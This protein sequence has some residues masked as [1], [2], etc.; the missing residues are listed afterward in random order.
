MRR[1]LGHALM[2]YM[3]HYHQ[4]HPHQ[5]PGHIVLMPASSL[6]QDASMRCRE[7]FGGLLQY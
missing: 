1:T 7:P 2:E 6:K 4:E 3:A 5:G